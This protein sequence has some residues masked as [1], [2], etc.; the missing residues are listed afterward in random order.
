MASEWDIVAIGDAALAPAQSERAAPED[1]SGASFMQRLGAG[2]K[3]SPQSEANYYEALNGPG[4]A[5]V[6]RDG[7]VEIMDPASGKWKRANPHGLDMGDVAGFV[8]NLPEIIGGAGG[9]IVA[10]AAG[11]AAGGIGAIPAAIAGGVAGSAGGNVV[12][13]AIGALLPGQEAETLG[14]RAT[15][16]G[17]AFV[18]GGVG[19]GAG[20]LAYHGAI[21]PVAQ[22][23]MRGA[24]TKGA[25]SLA[26]A[27]AIE[28]SMNRGAAP[29]SA[30]FKLL[31]GEA[32]GD[33]TLQMVEEAARKD[34]SGAQLF[35]ARTSQDVAAVRDKALRMV[36]DVRGGAR[37]VSDLMLG[38]KVG[39]VFKEVDDAMESALQARAD[40]DF[41][42]LKDPIANRFRFDTPN[43]DDALGRLRSADV[44]SLG[45]AGPVAEGIDKLVADLPQRM[46]A[47]DLNLYLKRFG[48]IGYGKGDQT[49]LEKLGDADKVKVAKQM[50]AALSADVEQAAASGQP[51]HTLATALRGA[52]DR[53]AAGLGEMRDWQDG[54]FAKV[55]GD[56]GPESA[57]KIVDNIYKLKPDELKSVMT[58]I[59]YKPEVANAVRANYVER[60]F[61]KSQEKMMSR[62]G[63]GPWFDADSFAKALGDSAQIEALFGRTH[64]EVLN[65]VVMMRRAVARMSSREFNTGTS[66]AGQ[67]KLMRLIGAV[68]HPSRWADAVK[69]VLVPRKMTKIL[70]DPRAREELKLVANASAPTQRVVAAITYLTGQGIAESIRD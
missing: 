40:T 68:P 15:D 44:N 26:E 45:N 66:V 47:K 36:D 49:F 51:G 43:F 42:F 18:L 54:L 24:A 33:R 10:G 14:Q 8:G 25:P 9:A 46:T 69:Q 35:A 70:L 22:A 23:L 5:R 59:G 63:P 60:A 53:Y 17:G 58:V 61:N 6:T 64:R 29:G 39:G 30:P 41:A 11:G 21:R 20:Q 13:Q 56:Y 50:F 52:K 7:A 34:V 27:G 62:A 12:R 37:P 31:P 48:R 4:S 28:A 55:V 57:S 32:T 1:Q 38:G 67:S 16:V 65:D 3:G 2:F 19:E